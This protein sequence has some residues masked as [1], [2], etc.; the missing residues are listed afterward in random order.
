MWESSD[1]ARNGNYATRESL[2]NSILFGLIRNC[3]VN[4]LSLRSKKVGVFLVFCKSDTVQIIGIFSTI[5][6]L[7]RWFLMNHNRSSENP[8]QSKKVQTE[9][10]I[11]QFNIFTILSFNI[12]NNTGS[13]MRPSWFAAIGDISKCMN[14]HGMLSSWKSWDVHRDLNGSIEIPLLESHFTG[15]LLFWIVTRESR[16]SFPWR[17][18]TRR[19]HFIDTINQISWLCCF[20]LKFWLKTSTSWLIPASQRTTTRTI[21]KITLNSIAD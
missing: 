13:K 12:S 17:L 14:M 7:T 19:N 1:V 9:R 21:K 11:S 4:K 16:W 20:R 6:S 15:H 10:L 8:R 18:W 5:L 2:T 3:I